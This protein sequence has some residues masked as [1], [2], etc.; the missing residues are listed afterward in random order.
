MSVLDLFACAMG[1]FLLIAVI[2]L[3]YY[4]KVIPEK[5]LPNVDIVI[6]LDTTGSMGEVIESLKQEIRDLVAVLEQ[7]APSVAVG[8][9][10]FND[11]R[12]TPTTHVIFPLQVITA[13]NGS[14][15]RLENELALVKAGGAAGVN[16]DAPE[17]LAGGFA[18]ATESQWR[19][20]SKVQMIIAV[21]DV[22]PHSGS[23]NNLLAMARSFAADPKRSVTAVNV[24]NMI[25]RPD[26]HAEVKKFMKQLADAGGGHYVETQSSLVAPILLGLLEGV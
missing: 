24:G 16:N 23:E 22:L 6:A 14:V 13:G 26:Y 4:K 9:V 21:T 10:G 3:P 18:L 25:E 19:T 11:I 2:V 5:Q 8:V 15:T 17:N 7:L 20:H 12:Q 1:A